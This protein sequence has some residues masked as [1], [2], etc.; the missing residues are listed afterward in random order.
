VFA[1]HVLL[2]LHAPVTPDDCH[3]VVCPSACH[4]LS[5]I[6]VC[7]R[8]LR[9]GE[10]PVGGNAADKE[11]MEANRCSAASKIRALKKF[12]SGCP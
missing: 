5:P 7:P 10:K 4:P 11:T 6:S 9:T 12:K 1:S 8:R 2:I 3:D